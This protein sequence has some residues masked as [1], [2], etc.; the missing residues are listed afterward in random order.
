MEQGLNRPYLVEI[1]VVDNADG[2]EVE[3]VVPR[4]VPEH[5]KVLAGQVRDHRDDRQGYQQGTE[6]LQDSESTVSRGGRSEDT[7]T[8]R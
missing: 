5:V 3:V 7:H 2:E 8:E 4:I 6:H 1:T